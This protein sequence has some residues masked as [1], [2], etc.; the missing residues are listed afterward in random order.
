[1]DYA[2][3]WNQ[4]GKPFPLASFSV[5]QVK[6]VDDQNSAPRREVLYLSFT[7][8]LDSGQGFDKNEMGI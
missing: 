3:F 4:V 1:M 8:W 6:L 7:N 5:A 2:G